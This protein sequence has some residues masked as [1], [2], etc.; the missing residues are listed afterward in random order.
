M[1]NLNRDLNDLKRRF[2]G[3]TDPGRRAALLEQIRNTEAAILSQMRAESA[4]LATENAYM[5]AALQAICRKE[6]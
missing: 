2:E 5:E 4:R 1:D 6:K 3:E